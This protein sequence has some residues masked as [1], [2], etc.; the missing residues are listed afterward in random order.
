MAT[1]TTKMIPR[2]II[3]SLVE[4]PDKINPLLIIPINQEPSTAPTIQ[5]RPPNKLV[6]PMATDEQIDYLVKTWADCVAEL[7]EVAGWQGY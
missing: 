7:V 2:A 6:P 1:A 5:A 4:K 3:C